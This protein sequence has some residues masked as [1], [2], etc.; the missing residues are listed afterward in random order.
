MVRPLIKL[1]LMLAAL[2]AIVCADNYGSKSSNADAEARAV[3][4]LMREVPAWSKENGCFSCHN[5]GDAA[6]ALYAASRKGR[7]VP[8]HVLADTTEWVKRPARWDDN[9][10]DP[11][12]SDKRLA[13]IQFAASLLSAIQTGRV[14]DRRPLAPD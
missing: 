10:G 5:N 3:G 4:F 6:R 7:R 2:T 13:D 1:F 14:K 8:D 11:G 9:K 12:F